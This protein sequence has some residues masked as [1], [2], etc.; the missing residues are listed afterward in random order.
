MVAIL[1]LRSRA[2]LST[3]ISSSQPLSPVS[4]GMSHYGESRDFADSRDSTSHQYNRIILLLS[5]NFL[6]NEPAPQYASLLN[7]LALRLA[8]A[9]KS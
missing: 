8:F 7:G 6:S 9:A 2:N 1:R 3:V 5:G 4:D